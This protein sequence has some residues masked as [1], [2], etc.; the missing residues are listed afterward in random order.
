MAQDLADGLLIKARS[1]LPPPSEPLGKLSKRD[2]KGRRSTLEFSLP[3]NVPDLGPEKACSQGWAYLQVLG[4]RCAQAY[5]RSWGA[6]VVGGLRPQP[7][8]P[9]TWI[10][11]RSSVST[12]GHLY[13][14]P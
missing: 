6:A 13:P 11:P 9:A 3:E 1:H 5:E 2:R 10:R 12:H 14:L 8:S 4:T 7:T